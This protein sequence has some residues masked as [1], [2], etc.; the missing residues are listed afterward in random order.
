MAMGHTHGMKRE[1]LVGAGFPRPY[2]EHNTLHG[3]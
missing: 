2:C 3:R 1:S